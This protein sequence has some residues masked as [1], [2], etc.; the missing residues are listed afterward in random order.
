MSFR[1]SSGACRSDE[2]SLR[3]GGRS[4]ILLKAK[5]SGCLAEEAPSHDEETPQANI[6]SA[7]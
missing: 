1:A 4:V 6:T 3:A 7:G 5:P 2:E